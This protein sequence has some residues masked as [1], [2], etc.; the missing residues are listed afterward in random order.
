MRLCWNSGA[1][2]VKYLLLALALSGCTLVPVIDGGRGGGGEFKP[3]HEARTVIVH[4]VDPG[5]VSSKCEGLKF[6]ACT[7]ARTEDGW[8]HI[9]VMK[10]KHWD[11]VQSFFILG[12]EVGHCF[13]TRKGIH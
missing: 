1:F 8:C 10:P 9:Y 3:V 5:M 4:W 2:R 11:D 6:L 13:D 12:H 7:F